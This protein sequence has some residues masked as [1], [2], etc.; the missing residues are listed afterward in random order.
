MCDHAR[1]KSLKSHFFVDDE[2]VVL[3]SFLFFSPHNII[4]FAKCVLRQ[5]RLFISSDVVLIYQ[6]NIK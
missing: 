4:W 6:F 1:L 3:F 2:I 5:S